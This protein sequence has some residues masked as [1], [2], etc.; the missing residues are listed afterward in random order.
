MIHMVIVKIVESK[1][2]KSH[3]SDLEGTLKL[4]SDVNL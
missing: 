1:K 3:D 4:K 2:K